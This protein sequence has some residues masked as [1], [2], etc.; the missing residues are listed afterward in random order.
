MQLRQLLWLLAFPLFCPLRVSRPNLT[1]EK[2]LLQKTCSTL[3]LSYIYYLMGTNIHRVL[4][5]WSHFQTLSKTP[6]KA[7]GGSGTKYLSTK[8]FWR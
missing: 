2:Y 8:E 4:G 7:E 6:S 5:L 3:W 1:T